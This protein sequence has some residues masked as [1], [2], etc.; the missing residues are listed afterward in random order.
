V[1]SF[2]GPVLVNAR[3]KEHEGAFDGGDGGAQFV[4]DNGDKFVFDAIYFK[5]GADVLNVANGI[6]G[7]AIGIVGRRR[8]SARLE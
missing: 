3:A 7:Q 6:E 5:P 4:A 2:V 1:L 8:N